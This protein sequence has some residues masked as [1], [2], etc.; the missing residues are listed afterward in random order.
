M[1]YIYKQLVALAVLSAMTFIYI[2]YYSLYFQRKALSSIPALQSSVT[3]AYLIDLATDSG[4]KALGD[5]SMEAAEVFTLEEGMSVMC[6]FYEA[7][8]SQVI[9]STSAIENAFGVDDRYMAFA[10]YNNFF[11]IHTSLD[12]QQSF[13]RHHLVTMI[14]R[15]L[16]RSDMQS[17]STEEINAVN[18]IPDLLPGSRMYEDTLKLYNMGIICGSDDACSL[19]PYGEVTYKQLA[20]VLERLVK[21]ETRQHFDVED[22]NINHKEFEAVL[23]NPELPTGCEVTS[24]TSV[25]NHLGYDVDKCTLADDYLDKG[26]IGVTDYR[27]AFV[28]NPR[29]LSSYGCF[30]PV[31]VN[32]ANKYLAQN[33]SFYRA[34][35]LSGTKLSDLYDIVDEGVPVII[36]GTMYLAKSYLMESWIIGTRTVEWYAN[37]HCMV[38]YGV[39]RENGVLYVA[40]PLRGNVEYPEELF[41]QRYNEMFMQA[42]VIK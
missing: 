35:D 41:E 5:M 38:L 21:P 3:T 42:V 34:H 36:W 24:L 39:D 23:Q 27:S 25:L 26:E 17:I 31:I 2:H 32:C 29:E 18:N 9:P 33:Q 14:S 19:N 22:V 7:E 11:D 37:E 12:T 13:K 40:D 28:G 4:K 8:S 16:E 20:T 30:A 1:K 6:A 10:L 15:L